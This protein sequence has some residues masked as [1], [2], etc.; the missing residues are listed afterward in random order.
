MRRS[1][2]SSG[3]GQ[4]A[5]EKDAGTSAKG[6]VF[7]KVVEGQ[8]VVVSGWSDVLLVSTWLSGSGLETSWTTTHGEGMGVVKVWDALAI[9]WTQ[10]QPLDWGIWNLRRS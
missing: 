4:R 8:R 10:Q 1:R 3:G 7:K 9:C 5:E 2:W 6:I